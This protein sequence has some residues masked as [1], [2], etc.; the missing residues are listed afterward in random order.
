MRAVVFQ[1]L[2]SLGRNGSRSALKTRRRDCRSRPPLYGLDLWTYRGQAAVA[3]GSRIGHEFLG[4]VIETGTQ[5]T[6][7]MLAT[8]VAPFA[9]PMENAPSVARDSALMSDGGSGAARS[10]MP[11][12]ANW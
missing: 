1:A 9:I 10:S 7:P 4:R 8:G 2:I 3:P 5:V 12:R 6:G 11:A